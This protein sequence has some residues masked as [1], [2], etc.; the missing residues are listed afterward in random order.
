MITIDDL[1]RWR[2]RIVARLR[3]PRILPPEPLGYLDISYARLPVRNIELRDG[4]FW[5]TGTK[6]NP[7]HRGLGPDVTTYRLL[8][9]EGNL[10][11]EGRMGQIGPIIT[12]SGMSL[13]LTIRIDVRQMKEIIR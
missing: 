3:R 12:T 7:F 5:V 9:P 6:L 8:D 13:S 1:T 2:W 11:R 4:Q 10:V